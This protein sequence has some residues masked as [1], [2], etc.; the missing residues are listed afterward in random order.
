MKRPLKVCQY[1]NPA[2]GKG[3]QRIFIAINNFIEKSDGQYVS[4]ISPDRADIN[5][6]QVIGP[7]EAP[8]ID[9]YSKSAVLMQHCYETA[10]PDSTDYSSL[11]ER[12]L[13][14]TSF[15]NLPTYTNKK[16]PFL[17]MPLGAD[18]DVFKFQDKER[19]C[20]VFTTGHVAETECIDLLYKACQTTNQKFAH[21]GENFNFDVANYFFLPYM[22]D[23]NLVDVLNKTECTFCMRL[24]EGF[25]M[26]GVEGLLCGAR[27]IVPD[28]PCY[29]W[30][31]KF[32]YTIRVKNKT[33]EEIVNQIELL[34]EKDVEI[35]VVSKEEMLEI[36]NIF[37]WDIVLYNMFKEIESRL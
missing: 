12:C 31:R 30:Y 4:E 23:E 14:V 15:N 16:F 9:K 25:E 28:L 20:K 5:I 11:W 2:W 27:P 1:F 17:H 6:I 29:D 21:T 22:S 24:I 35:P 18:V 34:L 7:G 32:G 10:C 13:L 36:K 37:D 19:I 26:L 3:L 33:N 8:V